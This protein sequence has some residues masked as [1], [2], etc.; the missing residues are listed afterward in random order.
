MNLLAVLNIIILNIVVLLALSYF[1]SHWTYKLFK[2]WQ[3]L[4]DVKNK[5]V[6]KKVIKLER[7]FKDKNRFY[8][9]WFQLRQIEQNNIIGSLAEVGVFKGETAKLMHNI[10][11]DRKLYL[12]DSF[13][14]F[15]K[16]VIKEDCDGTIRPQTVNFS[17][18]SKEKVLTYI[19]G[20]ENIIVK[21]G[22]FPD[23]AV[24]LDD[25]SYAFV[26]L[27]ADLFQSTYDGFKYFYPKLVAGGMILV[28]DYNHNWEGVKKAVDLF[29]KEVPE[30]FIALNDMYGSMI[31][32]KNKT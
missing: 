4:E 10:F 6:N 3:W 20:N 11:P 26:H 5:V 28:H 12:F 17:N 25:E 21:E 24:D 19:N 30:Q 14:G 15:P 27:D 9:F 18:T 22:I 2:P 7:S 32:V 31:L 13:S 8:S 1:W 29:E 16:Q 23:T